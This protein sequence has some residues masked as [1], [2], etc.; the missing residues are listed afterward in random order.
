MPRTAENH[1]AA[2]V[3]TNRGG[4]GWLKILIAV[5]V[6]AGLVAGAAIWALNKLGH[7]SIFQSSGCT[8]TSSAG[9][10]SLDLE[11]AR[12][13]A[14]ISAVGLSLNVPTF[15]IQVALATARQESKLHD[16][17]YGDRDSVGLFQ[18]RPSQGWGTQEQIM[19]PVY[20]STKFYQALLNV[21]GWQ[22]MSLTQAAQAVQHSGLPDAY[23]QY[24]QFAT[25]IAAVFTGGAGP[26][27]GCTLDGP[28][29]SPQAK[30]AGKLL[31]ARGQAV[32][33]DLRAQFG[34][35]NVGKVTGFGADGGSFD[36]AAP[37]SAAGG[38]AAARNWAFANWAAAQAETLGVGK[39][40]YG[41]K[42]WNASDGASG[43]TSDSSAAATGSSVHIVMVTGS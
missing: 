43:W 7:L 4:G 37:A 34:T 6:V 20:A 32:I 39:V 25:V 27:L 14:T 41:G 28:T 2:P 31:T 9:S 3:D 26:G 29:F 23:A 38:D 33:D 12:N 1:H 11:Q 30:A 40:S 22:K 35:A 36:V 24:G 16:I 19:D 21:P 42:T 10:M 13:A 8:A 5:L 15:G 17:G 18:Q